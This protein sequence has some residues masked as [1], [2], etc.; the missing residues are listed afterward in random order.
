M[1]AEIRTFLAHVWQCKRGVSRSVGCTPQYKR[2]VGRSVVEGVR[3]S[4]PDCTPYIYSTYSLYR[5][6][7]AYDTSFPPLK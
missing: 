3:R 5:R 7:R 6:T 2:G 4:A 1:R